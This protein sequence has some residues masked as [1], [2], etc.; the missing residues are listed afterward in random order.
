VRSG[1]GGFAA[2][3]IN[4]CLHVTGRRPDGYHLLDSVAVFAGVGDRLV[5]EPDD[6][7]SLEIDGPF[8]AGLAA[9][10]DNLV[11]RA[12]RLLG[13]AAGAR[14]RLT[15][16]LPVASGIGGGSADAAA[17]LRV[18]SALWGV[19]ADLPGLALR[20]GADVPVCLESRP[21]RMLG[22]GE[23]LTE[24]AVPRCG[25]VLVNPG[26][27]VATS[28]VF[29][30]LGGAFSP[31]LEVRPWADAASLASWLGGT[32]N[33]LQA[34]AIGLCPPIGTVLDAIAATGSLIARMSGSGATCF[35]LYPTEEAA[36]Q[37]VLRLRQPGWWVWG[38]G[39][40]EG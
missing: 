13:G 11:M 9:D 8:G 40:L 29:R 2:A 20:L 10:D 16:C 22:V 33:D 39:L 27:A 7:L 38:G 32:S 25:L 36:I 6:G 28:A 21:A 19:H 3:K 18:L 14:L 1:A 24:V 12:A 37:A 4:L 31:P 34:A 35:G 23:V 15:K 5:A 30:A 26:V 17:A